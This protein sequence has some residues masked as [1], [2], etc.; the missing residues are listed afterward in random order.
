VWTRLLGLRPAQPGHDPGAISHVATARRDRVRE[1]AAYRR[2][3]HLARGITE[4]V[5]VGPA[6]GRCDIAAC[7]NGRRFSYL[8][9]PPEGHPGEGECHAGD[10]CR[11][12]ARP[13]V[14][15]MRRFGAAYPA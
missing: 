6:H 10:Y 1:E 7:N 8:N 3:G 11:C 2:Y 5:W 9:P 15:Q 4:Y 14:P 13:L 12:S